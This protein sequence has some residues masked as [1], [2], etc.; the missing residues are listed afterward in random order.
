LNV[1][2]GGTIN[3]RYSYSNGSGVYAYGGNFGS[4]AAYDTNA[5]YWIFL[6][7]DVSETLTADLV[8][9]E[10]GGVTKTVADWFAEDGADPTELTTSFQTFYLNLG[11]FISDVGSINRFHINNL[12]AHAAGFE[13]QKIFVSTTK[14]ATG[15]TVVY[16]FTLGT[17]DAA[18]KGDAYDVSG[19]T[20]TGTAW[21]TGE[22]PAGT[23]VGTFA[24][25]AGW[26]TAQTS[27]TV[28][29]GFV[30]KNFSPT[31]TGDDITLEAWDGG[32]GV[33]VQA[34]TF[35]DWFGL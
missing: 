3:G 27:S 4:G 17:T 24:S 32:G 19:G 8:R 35:A 12:S 28:Y 22:L 20:L 7:R 13:I 5:N 2:D 11:D 10:F 21:S 9:I 26:D 25:G 33:L 14:S 1:L 31:V 23:Y 29:W 18:C 15:A 16:D 34:H 30:V 6:A